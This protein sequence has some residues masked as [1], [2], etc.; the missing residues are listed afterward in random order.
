MV[1]V[2]DVNDVGVA[3]STESSIKKK[4]KPGLP[5]SLVTAYILYIP[6]FITAHVHVDI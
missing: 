4:P 3:E 6:D 5:D 2:S 1:V